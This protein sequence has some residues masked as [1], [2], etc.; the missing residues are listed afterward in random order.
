MIRNDCIG[1]NSTPN[2][3]FLWLIGHCFG[4]NFKNQKAYVGGNIAAENS[5][6]RLFSVMSLK[7]SRIVYCDYLCLVLYL[8]TH[9]QWL[10]FGTHIFLLNEKLRQIYSKPFFSQKANCPTKCTESHS[11][12]SPIT[13]NKLGYNVELHPIGYA[14]IIKCSDVRA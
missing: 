2:G 8:H 14:K 11:L 3:R 4:I 12:H 1:N 6:N 9:T 7:I 13:N 5:I 10:T